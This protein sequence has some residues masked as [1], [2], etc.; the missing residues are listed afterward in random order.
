[1]GSR[2]VHDGN[3]KVSFV[4][5]ITSIAAPTV[6]QLGAGTDLSTFMTK[7]GLK[8]PANQNNADNATLADTFDAETIGSEG[9][10]CELTMY[11]ETPTAD[12][13]AWN[14]CVRGTEGYLVVRRLIAHDTAWA[15]A[16]VVEVYPVVMHDPVPSDTT[17]NENAKFTCRMPVRLQPNRKAVVAA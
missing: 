8:V 6:A 9:G 1:M 17:R 5:T 2:K 16:Q 3:T 13:D 11:R 10:Q 7:D 15:A 14:L 4:L 12:D